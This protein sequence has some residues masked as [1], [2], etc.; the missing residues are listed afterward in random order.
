MYEDAGHALLDLDNR[1]N[2]DGKPSVTQSDTLLPMVDS[3]V[4]TT[5]ELEHNN[6]FTF[7]IKQDKNG[8]WVALALVNKDS[9][10]PEKLIGMPLTDKFKADLQA[11]DAHGLD[12][13]LHELGHAANGL[14]SVSSHNEKVADTTAMLWRVGQGEDG[15]ADKLKTLA[16][17]RALGLGDVEHFS[18]SDA[19]LRMR[20]ELLTDPEGVRQKAEGKTFSEVSKTADASYVRPSD[21][22]YGDQA[23]IAQAQGFANNKI[24]H[25][26]WTESGQPVPAEFKND[27]PIPTNLTRDGAITLLRI[28]S[29]V[30]ENT[31]LGADNGL[32]KSMPQVWAANPKAF[33]EAQAYMHNNYGIDVKSPLAPAAPAVA[34][35]QAPSLS[36]PKM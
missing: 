34:Q 32:S 8:S 19:L 9:G 16:D 35:S 4:S 26:A 33:A 29:S 24:Y 2:I 23:Q 25:A 27:P 7:P 5:S 28:Q 22:Q 11:V 6:S 20:H 30:E 17:S 12:A 31:K 3:M 21:T 13:S 1:R 14:T 18:T 15:M 36:Q 10:D